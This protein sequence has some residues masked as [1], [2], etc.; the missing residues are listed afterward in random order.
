MSQQQTGSIYTLTDPRDDSIRYVGRTTQHPLERLAGHLASASNPAMRVWLNALALQGLTPRL[1][2]IVRPLLTRL[3]EE[4]QHQIQRHAQAGHRLFNAPHYHQHIADLWHAA[5]P[6]PAALKRNDATA[7]KVDEYA[8]RLYGDVAAAS[9]AGKITRWQA[10]ARVLVRVPAVAAVFLWHALASIAPVRWAVKASLVGYFLWGPIGLDRL[11]RD[12][13]LPLLPVH[14][15]IEFWHTYL[16]RPALNVA[17]WLF[18]IAVVMGVL[19]YSSVR[20]TA[21]AQPRKPRG[22]PRTD[23]GAVDI[24]AAAAAALDRAIP[25]AARRDTRQ[26]ESD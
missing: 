23:T 18:G 14:E 16:E 15:G 5:A 2:V 25:D 20:E 1:D 6:T 3:D 4:E 11:A 10:A 7:T 21:A 24:A 26:P 22:V 12:K 19:S 13:L 9:A 17:L 8:H